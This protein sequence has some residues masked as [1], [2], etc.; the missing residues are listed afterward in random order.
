MRLRA[1]AADESGLS[2]F[3]VLVAILVL[4]VGLMGVY[5]SIGSSNGAIA[6]GEKTTVMAQAAEQQL[7]SVEALPYASIANSS[8]PDQSSTT[9]TSNPTYYLTSCVSGTCSS[10]YAGL[11]KTGT[12]EPIDLDATNGKV[13]PG[14]TTLVVADPNVSTCAS[15]ST[16]TCRVVLSVYTF[17][18]NVMPSEESACVTTSGCYKRITVAVKNAGQG[19]PKQP[20][21]LSTLIGP[22]GGG[23]AGNPLTSSS[24][25]CNDQGQ[26]VVCTH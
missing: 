6:A 1:R 10:F 16:A 4:A 9:D 5:V 24:T 14:P 21:Y 18:T 11:V 25:T 8:D 3:E 20:Y 22:K 12:A 23:G 7:E 17:V 19:P 2:L 26:N 13:A 15:T